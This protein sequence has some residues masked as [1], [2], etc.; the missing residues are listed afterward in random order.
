LWGGAYLIWLYLRAEQLKDGEFYFHVAGLATLWAFAYSVRH[1]ALAILPAVCLC[2]GLIVRRRRRRFDSIVVVVAILPLCMT[3]LTTFGLKKI[4]DVKDAPIASV[5]KAFDL[6]TACVIEE[7]SCSS[8]PYTRSHLEPNYREG[9]L[10]GDVWP[11]LWGDLLGKKNIVNDGYIKLHEGNPEIDQEYRNLL[12]RRPDLWIK[13]KALSFAPLLDTR[14]APKTWYYSQLEPNDFG[15]RLNER[16]AFVRRAMFG[17]AWRVWH[18]WLLRWISG[19]HLAWLVACSAG[20]LAAFYK[21]RSG[22]D[23]RA[24]FYVGLM[25]IPLSYY[26]SYLVATPSTE[27]RMMF[28]ATLFAQATLFPFAIRK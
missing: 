15:L 5:Q 23:S 21:F 20:A 16:F 7:E 12:F 26:L 27:F 4:F 2:L 25:L 9:Y 10:F 18:H 3:A 24:V 13:V 8:F 6:V 19:V 22:P 17:V 14:G 11:L 28:P 1:N